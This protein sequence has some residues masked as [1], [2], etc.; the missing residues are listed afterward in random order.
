MKKWKT[1]RYYMFLIIISMVQ[2][3]CGL[4]FVKPSLIKPFSA[5]DLL[6]TQNDLPFGWI[7]PFHIKKDPFTSK[8]DDS[9]Y[10]DI[11]HLPVS[12]KAEISQFVSIYKTIQQTKKGFQELAQFPGQENYEWSFKSNTADEQK[13][14]CY[15][16]SNLNYPICTWLGRYEK[17]TIEVIGRFNQRTFSIN[18]MQTLVKIIDEKVSMKLAGK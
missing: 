7:A 16:Y 12:E 13:F 14:S 2:M 15:T 3:N 5:S 1:L 17:I 9:Y 4:Q 6:L 8:P 11:F 10:I 18:E